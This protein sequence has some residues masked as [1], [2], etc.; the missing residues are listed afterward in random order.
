MCCQTKGLY[1]VLSFSSLEVNTTSTCYG[2]Y[3]SYWGCGYQQVDTIYLLI[4]KCLKI[5][6]NLSPSLSTYYTLKSRDLLHST[7][8]TP[9]I[10]LVDDDTITE[11]E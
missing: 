4:T 11:R 3:E 6:S 5:Y 2:V 10:Q 9:H 7:T 8:L 1:F